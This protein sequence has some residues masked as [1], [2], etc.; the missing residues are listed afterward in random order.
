MF[1][2]VNNQNR[3]Q[4]RSFEFCA[5]ARNIHFSCHYDCIL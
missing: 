2:V 5:N 1:F 4:S 3:L